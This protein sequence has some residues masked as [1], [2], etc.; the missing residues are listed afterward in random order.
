MTRVRH[1]ATVM[2][3]GIALVGGALAAWRYGGHPVATADAAPIPPAMSQAAATTAEIAYFTERA[4]QDPK[5]AFDRAT[6]ASLYLQRSR[7]TGD[8]ADYAN[9]ERLARESIAIRS[10]RNAQAYRMLAAALLTQHRFVDAGRAAEELVARFPEEPSHHALLAEIQ[11]ELGD[12]TAAN[13][14]FQGLRREHEHMAVAPRLARW[15]EIRGDAAGELAALRSVA[16]KALH[17]DDL[18]REQV[19]W[20]HLR[21][22]DHLVRMGR[23]ADARA[24]IDTGLVE[25]PNDFRLVALQARMAGLEGRWRDVIAYGARLGEAADLRTLALV[26]DAHAAVGDTAAAERY[27]ASLE[28]SVAERPEPFNRQWTQFRVDHRRN[29]PETVAL[30]EREI[31]TRKDVLGYD[32]LAW[33]LYQSGRHAEAQAAMR[34]ALRMGTREGTLHYHAGM[35]ERALGNHAAARRHLTTALAINPRFHHLYADSA[36]AVLR[37]R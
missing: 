17:R 37:G 23:F 12:Y 27:Y 28:A 24:V 29:L 33:G 25:E 13:R 16:R 20:F 31:A 8:F 7:E 4:A 3:A 34:Q 18:P 35:I 1:R 26:G 21:V 11:L 2:A 6:L 36:K 15:A 22:A 9:A 10:H 30:L 32:L 5:G 19:A 14:T